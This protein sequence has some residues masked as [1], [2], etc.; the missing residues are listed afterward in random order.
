MQQHSL[1]LRP[2]HGP[3]FVISIEDYQRMVTSSEY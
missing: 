1:E 3:S 2:G